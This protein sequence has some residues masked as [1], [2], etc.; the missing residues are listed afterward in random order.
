MQLKDSVG[1]FYPNIFKSNVITIINLGIGKR[2]IKFCNKK[3]LN[4]LLLPSRR[5]RQEPKTIQKHLKGFIE[6][7]NQFGPAVSMIFS[8]RQK[9]LLLYMIGLWDPLLSINFNL[10]INND[11][12]ILYQKEKNFTLETN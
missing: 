1:L 10:T 4:T 7:C 8:F 11:I 5:P 9:T 12:L 3:K 6:K 2:I